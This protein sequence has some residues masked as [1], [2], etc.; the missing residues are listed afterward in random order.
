[1]SGDHCPYK[2]KKREHG[3]IREDSYVKMG[4]DTGLISPEPKNVRDRQPAPG[5]EGARA[6]GSSGPPGGTNPPTP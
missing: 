1:M 6:L 3:N 2:R 5:V 4:A